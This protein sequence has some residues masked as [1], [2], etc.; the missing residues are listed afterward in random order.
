MVGIEPG[1]GLCSS[2]TRGRVATAGESADAR[3]KRMLIT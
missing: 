2:V 1:V 3:A